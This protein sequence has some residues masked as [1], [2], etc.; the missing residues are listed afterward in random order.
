MDDNVVSFLTLKALSMSRKKHVNGTKINDYYRGTY[1]SDDPQIKKQL[2]TFGGGPNFD[3]GRK[4]T[5]RSAVAAAVA[6]GGWGAF[7]NSVIVNT[8]ARADRP[9][10]MGHWIA[11]ITQYNSSKNNFRLSFFDSM[12]GNRDP[13]RYKHIG[14]TVNEIL[15]KCRRY[16]IKYEVDILNKTIQPQWSQACGIYACKAVLYLWERNTLRLRQLFKHFASLTD[17]TNSLRRND[18]FVMGYLKKI[19]PY[20]HNVDDTNLKQPLSQLMT[21]IRPPQFCP[22]KDFGMTRQCN[23][24]KC[25]CK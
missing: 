1:M 18:D 3:S 6:G 24:N 25:E 22:Q 14:S 2:A 20:C 23:I 17:G 8:L 21:Q 19:W 7:M 10:L 4:V 12:G 9:D 13:T 11:I 15:T 5:H 16:G